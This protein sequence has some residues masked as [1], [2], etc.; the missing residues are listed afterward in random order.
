[1]TLLSQSLWQWLEKIDKWLFLKINTEWTSGLLDGILPWWREANAWVPLYLFLVVFGLLNFRK[2]FWLW[3]L[4]IIITLVFTDQMSSTLF[5]KTFMRL[6]PCAD[7]TL[8]GQ[9]RLLLNHCSGGFSFTSSHA[10]NHVGFAVFLIATTR[11]VFGKARYLFLL[12]AATISYGQVY[13]GVHFPL[14][15]V[16]GAL[17]GAALGWL[18]S[19]VYLRRFGELKPAEEA[20]AAHKP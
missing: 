7:D 14:D 11:Q 8:L 13:V 4:F 17:L 20:A 3:L 15:I 9:V 18:T 10:A 19:S 6:R 16:C 5:K 12:W 1:M 2:Q